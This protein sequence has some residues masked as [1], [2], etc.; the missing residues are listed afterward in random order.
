[1]RFYLTVEF[2]ERADT[3]SEYVKIGTTK[4]LPFQF[5]PRT[6]LMEIMSEVASKLQQGVREN[7]VLKTKGIWV[8]WIYNYRDAYA[9]FDVYS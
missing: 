6:S 4:Y 5:L 8:Q 1:M 2:Y 9:A 3:E 7:Q